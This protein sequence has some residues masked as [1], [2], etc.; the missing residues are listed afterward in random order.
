VLEDDLASVR[1]PVRDEG[2]AV[3]VRD[4]TQI[5]AVR[6]YR[7]NLSASIPWDGECDKAVLS[8]KCGVGSLDGPDK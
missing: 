4:L 3:H 6:T 5:I 8:R 2:V 1:R 7:V